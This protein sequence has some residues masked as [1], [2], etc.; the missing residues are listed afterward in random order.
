M[1]VE[2]KDFDKEAATWDDEP[3]RVKL[4]RGIAGAISARVKLTSD[5]D[6]L[7]FGCGTGLLTIALS[8]LV[9]SVT[10]VDSSR[11]M[12]DVLMAKVEK[13]N[14][15]N[16]KAQHV[17]VDNGEFLGG[18]YHLIVSS[19]TL[20]HVKEIGYLLNQFYMIARPAGRL[21]IVDLDPDDGRF[22]SE[23]ERVYH[24]GFVRAALR[25]AIAA[26]GFADVEDMTAAEVMK[27]VADG[28]MQLFTVF[29]MIGRK[30]SDR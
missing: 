29:L 10:A 1:T 22:H 12:L 28:R 8:S 15:S 17:Q 26:A 27:P 18:S 21:C 4:A 3:Q 2:T 30:I 11:G 7:D 20:H 23:N 24:Y 19:M 5:M 6:V 14:I 13:Q 25:K 9:R 16:V